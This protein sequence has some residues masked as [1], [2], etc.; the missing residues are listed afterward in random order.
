[1]V[2]EV[3]QA[4][5]VNT[6]PNYSWTMDPDMA[7]GSILGPDD[8]LAP[9]ESSCSGANNGYFDFRILHIY[10]NTVNSPN[11][12]TRRCNFCSQKGKMENNP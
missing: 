2:I 1:M 7:L 9:G 8:I 5:D 10:V 12:P 4:T 3:T 11:S 6:D